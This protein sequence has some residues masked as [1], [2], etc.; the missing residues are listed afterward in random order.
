M[1]AV[2]GCCCIERMVW[3]RLSDGKVYGQ[4]KQDIQHWMNKRNTDAS[5]NSTSNN[6]TNNRTS[7]Q[8]VTIGS[9][10]PKIVDTDI[11]LLIIANLTIYISVMCVF[12]VE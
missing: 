6:T 1:S 5:G 3:C 9:I 7:D 10:L 8:T 2:G 11:P 4:Q 12:M